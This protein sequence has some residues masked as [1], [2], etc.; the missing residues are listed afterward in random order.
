MIEIS[1]LLLLYVYGFFVLLYI[2][3]ALIN[4]YHLLVFGFLS[5]ESFFMTFLLIAGT[6]LILFITYKLGIA[7]DWNQSIII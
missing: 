3:F 5:F 6:I 4:I 2:I 1:L 7:I